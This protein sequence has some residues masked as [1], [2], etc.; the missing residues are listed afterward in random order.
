[1]HSADYADYTARLRPQPN[2]TLAPEEQNVYRSNYESKTCAPAER[3]VSGNGIRHRLTF[4][5]SGA[6]RNLLEVARSI[7]IT[8]LRDQGNRLENLV[9]TNKKL[10][11]CIT[12]VA[13]RLN[14]IPIA[15]NG[16]QDFWDPL[17]GLNTILGQ[18][19]YPFRVMN[20]CLD[21]L[22]RVLPWAG[23]IQCVRRK[24]STSHTGSTALLLYQRRFW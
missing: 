4:R 16:C 18:L 22:P 10:D 14:V 24:R 21:R 12:E 2:V 13:R 23:I 19:S 17:K 15:S 7:N 11:L 3:D 1:M 6:R 20:H 9:K 8:S 5:S